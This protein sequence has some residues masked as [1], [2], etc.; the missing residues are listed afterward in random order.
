MKLDPN[1]TGQVVDREVRRQSAIPHYRDFD[2]RSL[3]GEGEAIA[4]AAR[5]AHEAPVLIPTVAAL[6]VGAAA[7]ALIA[8]SGLAGTVVPGARWA[9]SPVYLA[10][11]FGVLLAGLVGYWQSGKNRHRLPR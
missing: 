6:I 2:W 8:Y 9:T 1:L 4:E 5:G 3:P 7:G 11:I 10:A